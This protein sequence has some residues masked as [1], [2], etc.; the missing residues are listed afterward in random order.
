MDIAWTLSKKWPESLWRLSGDSYD[1][2]EWLSTDTKPTLQQLEDAYAEAASER[3]AEA[4]ARD[5][6][7]ANA[8]AKLEA[9]G[10]TADE[11]AAIAGI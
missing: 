6:A 3:D 9:L 5:A 7:K 2:L 4:A 1:S 8:L 10:L 11:A